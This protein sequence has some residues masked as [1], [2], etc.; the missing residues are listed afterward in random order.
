LAGWLV[1]MIGMCRGKTFTFFD[2][3]MKQKNPWEESS[4]LNEKSG[5]PYGNHSVF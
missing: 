5:G 4:D 2:N 1:L 3:H